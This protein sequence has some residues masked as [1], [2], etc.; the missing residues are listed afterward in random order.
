[1][2]QGRITLITPPDIYENENTGVLFVDIKEKD[3]EIVSKW[4]ANRDLKKSYNF[5]VFSGEFNPTWLF[6]SIGVTQYKY[7][8][9]DT[10]NEIT[11]RLT[12]YLLGKNNIFYKTT[13]EN[14]AAI[15]SHINTNRVSNIEDF[16][17][18]VFSE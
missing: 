17:V 7:I 12:S 13:D 16:L 11:Q 3:Q 15:Y 9:I 4:L 8:D 10:S 14:L 6:Y 18:K 2:T 5:Y 1:M